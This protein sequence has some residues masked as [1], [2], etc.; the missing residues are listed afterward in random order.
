MQSYPRQTKPPAVF[1]PRRLEIGPLAL[2]GS[3]VLAQ[4][5]LQTTL[6][7][8]QV[9][10]ALFLADLGQLTASRRTAKLPKP[11]ERGDIKRSKQLNSEPHG[12]T[13]GMKSEK[14]LRIYEIGS[15]N[16]N[17]AAIRNATINL[18]NSLT[19]RFFLR[20]SNHSVVTNVV[21]SSPALPNETTFPHRQ[22]RVAP[23]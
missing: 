14:Q 17:P 3:G 10:R 2:N 4:V 8:D 5:H 23:G 20:A 21:D 9:R 13:P 6:E 15:E 22:R 18:E 1:L 16:R 11:G 7:R 12:R 19:I